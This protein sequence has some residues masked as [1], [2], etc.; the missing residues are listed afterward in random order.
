[1]RIISRKALMEFWERHPDARVPLESWY[2]T[3]KHASWRNIAEVRKV[4]PNADAAGVCTIFNIKGNHYRLIAAIH[5]NLQRV[6][7][8]HVLT[9][10]EYNRGSWK[11][12]CSG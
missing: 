12:D 7:I 8:R 2:R 5:Y 9:H 10:A 6:F 1:M 4:F 3:V 11:D